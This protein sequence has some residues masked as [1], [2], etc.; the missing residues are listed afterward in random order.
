MMPISCPPEMG[1]MEKLLG[2]GGPQGPARDKSG[3]SEQG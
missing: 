1:N 3:C 2:P